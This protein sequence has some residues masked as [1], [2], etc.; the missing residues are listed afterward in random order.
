[1]KTYQNALLLTYEEDPHTDF[2]ESKLKELGIDYLRINTDKIIEDYNISI[3]PKENSF[4]IE[5]EEGKFN[6]DHRWSVLNRRI[7]K[8]KVL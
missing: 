7:V 6:I 5:N 8:N 4:V 3:D 1:M 2:L